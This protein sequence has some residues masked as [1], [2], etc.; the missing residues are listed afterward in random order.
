MTSEVREDAA[1]YRTRHGWLSPAAL[2]IR[3]TIQLPVSQR[4]PVGYQGSFL[5]AYHPNK[6]FYLP[7]SLRK[8][9][10]DIGQVGLSALPAGTYLRQVMDRLLIDLS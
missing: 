4:N 5:D 8:E 1:V 6:T 9:L 3:G 10:E 2:E 7:E